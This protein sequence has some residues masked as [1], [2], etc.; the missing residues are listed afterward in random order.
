MARAGHHLR[1]MTDMSGHQPRIGDDDEGR[2]L[3]SQ[4]DPQDYVNIVLGYLSTA[5]RQP[6]LAPPA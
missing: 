5:A 6:D 3:Y 2:V 1:A 4:Q